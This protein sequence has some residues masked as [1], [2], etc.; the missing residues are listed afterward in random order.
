MWH[1]YVNGF[2]TM[3]ANLATSEND[4]SDTTAANWG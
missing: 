2:D 4:L 3:Q 1:N